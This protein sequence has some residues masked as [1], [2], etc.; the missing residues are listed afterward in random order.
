[1]ERKS[2]IGTYLNSLTIVIVG[3]F[4]FTFPLVFS[5]LSTD[6]YGIPKEIV[7]VSASL[8]GLVLWGVRMVLEKSIRLKN[9]PFNYPILF[10]A[11]IALFS[12]LV[13]I[14]YYDSLMAFVPLFSGIA[15]YF[16]IVNSV[17]DKNMAVLL[18]VPLLVS[19]T[20]LGVNAVLSFAK[21]YVLPFDFA[22]AQN[23]T[24]IGSY[25]DQAIFL[26]LILPISLFFTIPVLKA[27][28]IKNINPI[29]LLSL[30]PTIAIT[31]G[32]G[33]TLYGMVTK[34][35]PQILPLETGFQT[36]FAAISQDA[37][38]TAQGFLL[39]SGVGTYNIDF[40]RFK[41]P[42]FNNHD[43]LWTLQFFHSS[44]F[45]LELLATVGVLGLIAFALIVSSFIR[46]T[47]AHRK[48]NPFYIAVFLGF[49]L[50]VVLPFSFIIQTMLFVLLALFTAYQSY[51][52]IKLQISTLI[53]DLPIA[54]PFFQQPTHHAKASMIL[55]GFML[56]L[57]A[58]TTGFIGYNSYRF[59]NSDLLFQRSM[60]EANKN[61]GS[62]AYT[63]ENQAI[64]AFPYRDFYF[65]NL[66][67]LNL[68]LASS[69]ASQ[70]PKDSSPSAQVQ[71]TIS[72]LVQ[73]SISSAQS[74]TRIAPLSHTNWQNLSSIYR[75]LIGF[76][77]NAERLA[78]QSQMQANAL[79]PNNPQMY[80]TLGG[81]YY[82]LKQ[83]DSAQ[84]QFQV[85]INLKP[86]FANAYY[87]M[88]HA[89]ESKNDLKSA[90][91]QYQTAKSILSASKE[92]K[93]SLE[94][95]TKEIEAL[96]AK[97]GSA[98]TSAAQKQQPVTQQPSSNQPN[99]E[100]NQPTTQLPERQPKVELP[101][102]TATDSAK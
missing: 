77:Q 88:G 61:N 35:Q 76:G 57:I 49:V 21:I 20:V 71:Q 27:K 87:N 16:I 56:A 14:N 78:V 73:Q 99:I 53:E 62:A 96:E 48:T 51:P 15:I 2:E 29:S 32:L 98:D 7:L 36:A 95:L 66:S 31:L 19:A 63:L 34:F 79:N 30:I 22:K 42:S 58:A 44:N 84:N 13:S 17:K 8:L 100:L 72:S 23:F 68:A 102:P 54:S 10:F 80:L 64:T 47:S 40:S 70:Q 75:S 26:A 37:G 12:S 82:Q 4:L 55:P 39:G 11:V 83:W 74:A 93:E 85:A 52:E 5:P 89:L 86:N 46:N 1:M 92:N 60:I 43:T 9:A 38:R 6:G 18:S 97:I 41:Q 50:T 69:L 67:Q 94:S 90:L 81:L 25:F 91:V 59:V 24:P 3:L 65:R 45:I 28:N 101:G 33:I